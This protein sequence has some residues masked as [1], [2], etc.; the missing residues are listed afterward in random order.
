[1]LVRVT[2]GMSLVEGIFCALGPA[3]CGARLVRTIGGWRRV[4][5]ASNSRDQYEHNHLTN[6]EWDEPLSLA[7]AIESL[8]CVAVSKT[9]PIDVIE[10]AVEPRRRLCPYR[11]LEPGLC[12]ESLWGKGY[13]DVDDG[14]ETGDPWMS[15]ECLVFEEDMTSE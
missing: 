13:C 12:G 1:M 9:P 5:I 2:G 15:T 10:L 14:L 11:P 6:Q 3:A 8:P 4:A 7:S